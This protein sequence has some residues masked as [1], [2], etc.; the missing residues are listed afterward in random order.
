VHSQFLK[1]YSNNEYFPEA[2]QSGL[3]NCVSASMIFSLVFDQLR[4]PYKVVASSDHV[5][6]IANPGEHSIVIETTNPGFEKAIFTGEF[7]RQYVNYLRTSKLISDD[8]YK[9]KSIDEI[10]EEN[11]DEVRDAE[12]N[13][14]PGFQYYNKALTKMENNENQLAYELCQKAYF[15]YPD[16]QFKVLLYNSLLYQLEKCDFSKVADIDYLAQFS[17]F[18]NTDMSVVAGIFNNVIA[19]YLQYTDKEKYCDSLFNRL[20]LQIKDKATLEEVSF[21]Y[22]MQ[23]SYRYQNSDKVE[24][25]VANALKIKGN[26]QDA[27]SISINYIHRKLISM[28]NSNALLDTVKQLQFRFDYNGIRPVLKDYEMVAYLRIAKDSYEN[29]Q[30]K[31]GDKYLS[32]FEE[33]CIDPVE[34][35][36]PLCSA[37]ESTY[38]SIAVYYFYKNDKTMAKNLVNRGL[39][40]LPGSNL[41]KSAVY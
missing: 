9:N 38:H 31:E 20:V 41:I 29:K 6:L 23:M 5:Y 35:R 25:Y 34:N 11:F 17:R 24:H 39:K 10:F 28:Y 19:H 40:Y 2:F 18:E 26:H 32:L 30:V 15:F 21:S 7:K 12:F 1:K 13:N 8:E 4:I 27:N 22:F 14:L 16:Q 37:I 36:Q 33:K 3:Y